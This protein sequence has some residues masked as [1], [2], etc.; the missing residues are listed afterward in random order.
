MLRQNLGKFISEDD[1]SSVGSESSF[2]ITVIMIINSNIR[3][4][5]RHYSK[6]FNIP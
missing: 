5:T 6:T 4:G 2:I 1:I 3:L